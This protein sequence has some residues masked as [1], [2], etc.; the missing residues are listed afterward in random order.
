MFL[1]AVVVNVTL[2]FDELKVTKFQET[3]TTY[4]LYDKKYIL[5]SN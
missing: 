2:V 3:E 1:I 4:Q 5:G